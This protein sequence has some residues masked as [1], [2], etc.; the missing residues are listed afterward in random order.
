MYR[1][2]R[3]ERRREESGHNLHI[4]IHKHME[5]TYCGAELEDQG[6]WGYLALHQSGEVLGRVYKCPNSE[7]FQS[8]DE[9]K[10]YIGEYKTPLEDAVCESGLHRVSGCFYTDKNDNLH[11]GYPC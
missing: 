10:M 7:G 1:D 4:L 3:R 2:D 6:P 9:A 8:D 11:T 5:C